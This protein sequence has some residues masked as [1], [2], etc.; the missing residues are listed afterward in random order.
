MYYRIFKYSVC[1]KPTPRTYLILQCSPHTP[2]FHT[3]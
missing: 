1:R 2:Y 3:A